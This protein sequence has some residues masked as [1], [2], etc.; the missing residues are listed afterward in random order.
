M[1]GFGPWLR[2]RPLGRRPLGQR[3]EDAA[4]RALRRRGYRIL[5]RNLLTPE[6]EIDI[7]ARDAAG[8]VLVEVKTT[9]HAR[10]PPRIRPSQRRRLLRAGRWLARQPTLRTRLGAPAAFR[11]DHAIVVLDAGRFVVTIRRDVLPHR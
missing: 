9:T 8:L 5:A 4:A 2:R 1:F 10:R 3:G 6:A 7:L 11:V